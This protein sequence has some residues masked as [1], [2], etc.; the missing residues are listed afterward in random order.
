MVYIGNTLQFLVP[1]LFS[2]KKARR[3][4]NK[5]VV[6]EKVWEIFKKMSDV[7]EK[8]SVVSMG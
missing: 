4:N 6:S 1:T 8:K 3:F 7:S 5:S 2:A